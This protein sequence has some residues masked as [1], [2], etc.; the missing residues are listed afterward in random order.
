MKWN[1]LGIYKIESNIYLLFSFLC[2]AHKDIE[3]FA[4]FLHFLTRCHCQLKYTV[5][6]GKIEK[7]NW[8]NWLTNTFSSRASLCGF[9]H[10]LLPKPPHRKTHPHKHPLCTLDDFI[11]TLLIFAL[12]IKQHLYV[13]VMIAEFSLY[14]S[15]HFMRL[16]M[17]VKMKKIIFKFWSFKNMHT[18]S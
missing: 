2:G 10:I 5:V 11:F 16:Q 7:R 15:L 4:F 18:A 17:I 12:S 14:I 9:A 8:E 1:T 13:F 3:C 6:K